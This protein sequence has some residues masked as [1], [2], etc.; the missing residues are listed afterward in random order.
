MDFEERSLLLCNRQIIDTNK[1]LF[2]SHTPS[3]TAHDTTQKKLKRAYE[4]LMCHVI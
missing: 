3:N 1:V 4:V 2:Q